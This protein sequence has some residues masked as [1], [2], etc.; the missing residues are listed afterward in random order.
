MKSLS[1]TQGGNFQ[2]T[3]A[4]EG[5]CGG[6][7]TY[8]QS[9]EV[10]EC[11]D[12]DNFVA[13][14]V[15]IYTADEGAGA[16]ADLLIAGNRFD[17]YASTDE[18]LPPFSGQTS[19]P[20]GLPNANLYPLAGIY[21]QPMA[22]VF[23]ST[24]NSFRRLASGVVIHENPGATVSFDAYEEM[25]A[26]AAAYAGSYG[27]AG[28]ALRMVGTGWQTLRA[29][30]NTIKD[31]RL[32]IGAGEAGLTAYTNTISGAEY[33][34]TAIVNQPNFITIGDDNP[35]LANTVKSSKF[36]IWASATDP[37]GQV[38]IIGNTVTTADAADGEG[39][40]LLFSKGEAE[41]R[42]N[43]VTVDTAGMGIGLL[44]SDNAKV[45]GNTVNLNDA[46][47]ADAG[48]S[49]YGANQCLIQDNRISGAGT[50]G[51]QN[52]GIRI[53]Y[54]AGNTY[55]CNT[56]DNT[57]YGVSVV[58]P[59]MATDKFRGNTFGNHT[60][61]LWLDSPSAILGSQEHTENC[62][63]GSGGAVWSGATFSDG[64]EFPFLVDPGDM[65][66][67][68]PP[69]VT[70]AVGWF[71][72]FDNEN[73]SDV[74]SQAACVVEGFNHESPDIAKI[75]SGEAGSGSVYANTVLWSL[76]QYLYGETYGLV[77]SDTSLQN[78]L[79]THDHTSVGDFYSLKTGLSNLYHANSSDIAAM[80][81]GLDS[82]VQQ[83]MELSLL[84]QEILAAPDS[85]WQGLISNRNAH[86]DDMETL[87]AAIESYSATVAANR[88]TAAAALDAQNNGISVHAVYEQNRKAIYRVLLSYIQRNASHFTS[89]EQRAL[90]LIAQQCP[91]SGGKAVF[92]ARALL[93]IARD[94]LVWY[95]AACNQQQL[96][97]APENTS[98]VA[99]T[100]DVRLFP[101]PARGEVTVQWGNPLEMEG[102]LRV[103][104]AIGK[105]QREVVLAPG[106]SEYRL[107]LEGLEKGLYY[108]DIQTDS[109][110]STL[111]LI[112]S[113]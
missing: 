58:G 89:T 86:I 77:T 79:N 109:A 73:V 24:G 15:G 44:S 2:V 95:D 46:A 72:D 18:L 30:N 33:G 78:F 76:S 101:N 32:G 102:S 111:K 71:D 54:S 74:C 57:R 21:V 64:Q 91:L 8:T 83:L 49:L 35:N 56:V 7:Y 38:D 16:E 68:M 47:L 36:G 81:N 26:H 99:N 48:I 62:W 82:L 45:L 4:L 92:D 40:V 67:F 104:D 94:S 43:T 41:I 27:F 17:V 113:P 42:G 112:V 96:I 70:P 85:L 20:E 87:A 1:G 75:I 6:V 63:N 31:C 98:S 100:A 66:C 10:P 39:I 65:A 93:S 84:D 97:Q 107:S 5:D 105:L 12:D 25:D 90:E 29:F 13:N 19:G 103:F 9:L 52:E 23:A 28:D 37:N 88:T 11:L 106:A 51:A 14:F 61:G 22:S 53:D 55:C 50:G 108:L 59:S 69:S 80:K 3:L 34:I 60:A 110:Q